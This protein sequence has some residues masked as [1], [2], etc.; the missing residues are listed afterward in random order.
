MSSTSKEY[1]VYDTISEVYLKI[2]FMNVVASYYPDFICW[3]L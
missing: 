1:N 2:G 3:S